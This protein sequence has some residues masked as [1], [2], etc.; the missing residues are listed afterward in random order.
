MCALRADEV[1][2]RILRVP[3]EHRTFTV[4]SSEA[5]RRFGVD[6]ALLAELTDRGVP[7]RSAGNELMFD[8]SDLSNISIGLARA[9]PQ[10]MIMKRWKKSLVEQMRQESG[11]FE[12]T[13]SWRCPLPRHAGACEFRIAPGVAGAG[14]STPTDTTMT[15]LAEPLAE[16]HDFGPGFDYLVA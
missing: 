8:P 15:I 7:C 10:L 2:G 16:D 6:R 13:F 12:L 5:F 14:L 4:P 9:S 3:D 11:H 1:V